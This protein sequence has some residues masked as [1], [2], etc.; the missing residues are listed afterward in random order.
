MP[1]GGKDENVNHN[2]INKRSSLCSAFNTMF[3]EKNLK[4]I[5]EIMKFSVGSPIPFSL[6]D[7]AG[8]NYQHSDDYQALF[9]NGGNLSF[10]QKLG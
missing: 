1:M 6:K 4:D 9:P 5:M 2:N 10:L 8:L 7:M 3:V